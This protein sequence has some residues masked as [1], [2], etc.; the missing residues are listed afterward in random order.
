VALCWLPVTQLGYGHGGVSCRRGSCRDPD[1]I[2][3]RSALASSLQV[4]AGSLAGCRTFKFSSIDARAHASGSDNDGPGCKSL[5]P[6]PPG[7]T[8]PGAALGGLRALAPGPVL[9]TGLGVLLKDTSESAHERTRACHLQTGPGALEHSQPQPPGR[10]PPSCQ[11][12]LVARALPVP[13]RHLA[14]NLKLPSGLGAS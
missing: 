10:Q 8:R 14:A 6:A 1:L 4:G 12:V 3:G 11:C 9:F 5:V 13:P 7:R 2:L